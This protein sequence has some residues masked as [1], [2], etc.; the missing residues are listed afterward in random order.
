VANRDF[1][2]STRSFAD[3]NE[4]VIRELR[5]ETQRVAGW[6]SKNPGQVAA[7]LSD[8]LKIDKAILETVSRRRNWGFEPITPNM[9]AEQQNIANIFFN[10]RL[11]PRSV[12]V[13]EAVHPTAIASTPRNR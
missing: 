12:K 11:I 2:L 13:T 5:A 8:D 6:A 3:Q 1:Y 7:E 9:I 4:R 10:I